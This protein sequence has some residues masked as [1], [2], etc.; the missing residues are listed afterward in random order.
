MLRR[1]SQKGDVVI[2]GFLLGV[3]VEENGPT[4]PEQIAA[5]LADSLAFME[6]IGKV[7]VEVLG[8]VELYDAEADKAVNET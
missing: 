4:S 3:E 7:D 8:K 5:R 2:H 1:E 6:G